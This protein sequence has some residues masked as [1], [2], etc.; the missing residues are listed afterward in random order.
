MTD[1]DGE[2]KEVVHG[3]WKHKRPGRYLGSFSGN[4]DLLISS[5]EVEKWIQTVQEKG[6]KSIIC[7]L[8]D[9]ELKHYETDLIDQYKESFLVAHVATIDHKEITEEQL[10]QTTNASMTLEL[11]VLVHCSAGITRSTRV[12]ENIQPIIEERYKSL[13]DEDLPPA[14]GSSDKAGNIIGSIK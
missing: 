1:S 10:E 14:L 8:G 5:K 6:V 3:L 7:L 2:P 13:A 9:E 4:P 12:V 11:P